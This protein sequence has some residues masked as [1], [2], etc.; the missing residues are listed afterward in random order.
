MAKPLR[1]VVREHHFEKDLADL[2]GDIKAADDFVAAAEWLLA[3]NPEIGSPADRGS[4]VWFLPMAPIEDAQVA[5]F[6]TFDDSTVLADLARAD[7]TPPWQGIYRTSENPEV[8]ENGNFAP[9]P[10]RK[11]A[12]L[13]K[14]ACLRRRQ[15]LCVK[16]RNRCFVA[17]ISE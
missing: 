16:Q 9:E 7:V 2:V 15:G 3:R 17:V 5:L 13:E 10:V 6:Y 11:D 12:S 4:A 14:T 1:S 8:T